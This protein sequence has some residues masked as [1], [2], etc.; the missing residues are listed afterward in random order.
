MRIFKAA[1]E[2][3]ELIR[4]ANKVSDERGEGPKFGF[5]LTNRSF[6]V[7]ALGLVLNILILLNLPLL[8]PLVSL[9]QRLPMEVTAEY[10][11]IGV[12]ALSALWSVLERIGTRAK[13]IITKRQAEDALDRA[14]MAALNPGHN[15]L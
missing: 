6:L 15:V 10:I 12:T 13:V 4:L 7:P 3:I 5:L 8:G 2:I 11:V 14:L 1:K 9:L